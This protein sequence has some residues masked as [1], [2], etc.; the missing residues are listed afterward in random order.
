[1]QKKKPTYLQYL[2]HKN[3]HII[4]FNKKL[5]HRSRE[6]DVPGPLSQMVSETALYVSVSFLAKAE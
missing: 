6:R 4:R 2:K 5:E 1:M 3:T